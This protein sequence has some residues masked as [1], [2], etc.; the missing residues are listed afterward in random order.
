M[1]NENVNLLGL[2]GI[3]LID[4]IDTNAEAFF[5]VDCY[6]AQTVIL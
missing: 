3:I 5:L 1:C 4:Y 6:D 2:N